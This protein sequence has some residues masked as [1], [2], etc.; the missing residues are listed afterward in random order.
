MN[1]FPL[2]GIRCESCQSTLGSYDEHSRSVRL[3]MWS[4]IINS[5]GKSG[6]IE[7]SIQKL[8]CARMLELID[9]QAVYRFLAYDNSLE[10]SINSILV[11]LSTLSAFCANEMM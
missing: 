11:I 5:D 8:L 7:H 1:P 2:D 3:D 4:T 6:W 10:R 9:S